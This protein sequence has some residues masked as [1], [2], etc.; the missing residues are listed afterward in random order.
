VIPPPAGSTCPQAINNR[1][2]LAEAM[3]RGNTYVNV[4]TVAHPG[5]EIR[6]QLRQDD[7]EDGH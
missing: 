4:H 2:D 5:G 7:E 6:G 1:R 3:R